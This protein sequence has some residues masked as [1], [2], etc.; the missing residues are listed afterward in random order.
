MISTKLK[1]GDILKGK[2]NKVDLLVKGF[3][4]ETTING[5]DEVI[6][7]EDMNYTKGAIYF[8]PLTR[9]MNS[10]YDVVR[11]NEFYPE[12]ED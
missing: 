5:E 7:L 3:R 12:K 6:I 1:A 4:T 10:H 11:G 8:A 9:I 2:I